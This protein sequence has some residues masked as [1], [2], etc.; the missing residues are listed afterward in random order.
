MKVKWKKHSVINVSLALILLFGWLPILITP[1][2]AETLSAPPENLKVPPMAYNEEKIVLIWDKPEDY[3]TNGQDL[4][5]VHITDYEVYINNQLAGTARESFNEN[6]PYISTYKQAF[7]EGTTGHYQ[8]DI[9]SYT[10]TGLTPNTD[11]TFKV[12]AINSDGSFSS[13]SSPITHSTAKE[14]TIIDVADYGATYITSTQGNYTVKGAGEDEAT[15]TAIEENT[16]ALQAA[17][18]AVPYGGKVVLRGSGDNANPYYYVSGSLFL[19]SNMTFEIEEGAVL[20]GSPVFDHYSR[21]LLVYPYSQDIRTHG[22]LNAVTWDTGTLKNIRIVGNGA[23]DGNGWKRASSPIQEKNSLDPNPETSITD[24]TGNNW[25]LPNYFAGNNST[26]STHGILAGDAMDKSRLDQTPNSG[27]S[28]WYNT[29]PNLIIARGVKGLYYEGLTFYNPAFHGVVNYHSE[30]IVTNGTISLTYNT[31]NGD[32]LEYGD[33]HDIYIMNNFLDTGDDAINFAS[34]QGTTVRNETDRVASGEGVVFNNYVRN[35]HG[36]LLAIGSH[37]GGFIG[38]LKAEDN[39]YNTSETGSAGALRLKAGAIT[40]GGIRNIIF[41]DNALHYSINSCNPITIDTAYSDSNA[42]TAFGPESDLP[43]LYENI[44]IRNLTISNLETNLM[45][46]Q[47]PSTSVLSKKP[48]LRGFHLEDI[49]VLSGE[50]GDISIHSLEDSTFKNINKDIELTSTK[51]IRI[52]N[53]GNTPDQLP[54]DLSWQ[55]GSELLVAVEGSSLNISY[56]DLPNATQYRLLIDMLDGYGYQHK[57]VYTDHEIENIVLAPFTDYKIAVR[58]ETDDSYGTLLETTIRT[59]EN[60][61]TVSTINV[62][63]N[64]S[65][66]PRGLSGISWQA[67]TW[68]E[69]EDTIYGIH[70][71]ELTAVSES[72]DTKTYKA[73]FDHDT[74]A[75]YALWGLNAGERYDVTMKAVN[76]TGQ[77]VEY[78]GYSFTTVPGTLVD[79]PKWSTDSTLNLENANRYGEDITIQWNENDVSEFSNGITDI[80]AGYRVILNDVAIQP[81]IGRL[82]QTNA[83]PTVTPGTNSYVVSSYDLLP[84]TRYV[85]SVEA[86]NEILKYASGSGGLNGS[87]TFTGTNPE[88]SH[89]ARNQVTFGKWTGHGPSIELYYEAVVLNNNEESSMTMNIGESLQLATDVGKVTWTIEDSQIATIS[90][91]GYVSALSG[92]TTTITATNDSGFTASIILT[93]TAKDTD[94]IPDKSQLESYYNEVKDTVNEGYTAASWDHFQEALEDAKNVLANT[95]ATQEL[96]DSTLQQLITAFEGLTL[97]SPKE[98]EIPGN[99]DITQDKD[100]DTPLGSIE[101]N[102]GNTT[103]KPVKTG[104]STPI[105]LLV[106]ILIASGLTIAVKYKKQ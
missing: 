93:V 2:H 104:D 19:H 29:R 43:L 28:Q 41:R 23:I 73:Y 11:Y 14:P 67:L 103:P 40:G 63:T 86:G 64:T 90:E 81:E 24:P 99:E 65:L 6:Y 12:R 98:E 7:Y 69:A 9:H 45:T 37:V 51:N 70:Y 50:G 56:P 61:G 32:G 49:K 21:N 66:N 105:Y 92:G 10:A 34:G 13:F 96:I 74:R 62:P 44:N 47:E 77:S 76:W 58:P 55:E 18:D 68:E 78:G 20:F 22:L 59:Q 79:I 36:G 46:I 82:D 5:A 54:D 106:T 75:G 101:T 53:C 48:V 16:K 4:T 31:N 15:I 25:D 52:E 89:L 102:P 91:H 84:N 100:N 95:K 17:I 35:G 87:T 97:Q 71:Y 3:Y 39:L 88:T 94:I 57:G 85:L 72:G 8:I 30:G 26:V 38:D 60:T 83:L 27:V 80:F 42:S 33:C 1:S